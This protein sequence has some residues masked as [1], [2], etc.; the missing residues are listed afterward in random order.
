MSSRTWCFTWNNYSP[1]DELVLQNYD[2]KFIL[3]GREVASTGTR[4]LQGLLVLREPQRISFL[5]KNF[6]SR[7]HFEVCRNFPAS[8]QYCKKDGDFFLIDRRSKRGPKSGQPRTLRKD[9]SKKDEKVEEVF[10]SIVKEFAFPKC[11]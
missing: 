7:P 1:E 2:F 4:H 9:I 3:Y 6:G 10:R 11:L 8:V 5:K